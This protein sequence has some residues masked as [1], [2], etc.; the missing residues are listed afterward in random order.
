MGGSYGYC[1]GYLDQG[2]YQPTKNLGRAGF[3][4][5]ADAPREERPDRQS[6]NHGGRGQNVLFEDGHV[7]FLASS[8]PAGMTDDIFANDDDLV[9][10]GV[11]RDDSVIASSG[12]M[13]IIYVKGTR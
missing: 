3:A 8:R 10:A 12:V 9:A 11:H 4:L 2:V 6:A 5:M 13:P 7:Q 1:I